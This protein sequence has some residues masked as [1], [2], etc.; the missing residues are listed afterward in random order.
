MSY[1]KD[2]K[3]RKGR[4]DLVATFKWNRPEGVVTTRF[5][6]NDAEGR[7]FI[8]SFA[9][10]T[11]GL[12]RVKKPDYGITRDSRTPCL[13]VRQRGEAWNR[14]FVAVID[15][16]GTVKG[17]EFLEDIVRVTRSSGKVDAIQIKQ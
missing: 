9:P 13:V 3:A 11:E 1:I 15:P 2:K 5:F 12:S 16:C 8:Q 14:P 7:T 10:A 6:M 4:G 17:V